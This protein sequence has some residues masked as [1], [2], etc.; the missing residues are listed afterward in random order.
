MLD[1]QTAKLFKGLLEVL[2]E[3]H[4]VPALLG[5]VLL[6]GIGG[7]EVHVDDRLGFVRG[8]EDRGLG[9]EHRCRS[10]HQHLHVSCLDVNQVE[11]ALSTSDNEW[12]VVF[13]ESV[14]AVQR[15]LVNVLNVLVVDSL[16]NLP[17]DDNEDMLLSAEKRELVF[18]ILSNSL[19]GLSLK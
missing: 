15:V 8:E 18:C 17:I 1:R 7:G 4:N 3:G 10:L 14:E 19:D 13:V 9:V 5:F 12:E 16:L 11:C 2:P 6:S